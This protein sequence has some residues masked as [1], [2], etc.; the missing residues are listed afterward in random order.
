MEAL[1]ELARQDGAALCAKPC[2]VADTLCAWIDARTNKAR[3]DAAS[4]RRETAERLI[5]EMETAQA[6]DRRWRR[7]SFPRRECAHGIPFHEH[8]HRQ[9][10]AAPQCGRARRSRRP[11]GTR[12]G[13]HSSSPSFCSTSPALSIAGTADR[14]T[15]DLLFFPTGGGKTEAYLGLAAFVIAHRRLTGPGLLVPASP[16][17]CATPCAC[18]RSTSSPAPPA[19]SARSN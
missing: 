15:A 6:A 14:E 9:G 17:S 10:R 4:R 3:C 11:A 12:N 16:S 8:S 13:G 18:S 5:I 1:G 19:S 7:S 2:G